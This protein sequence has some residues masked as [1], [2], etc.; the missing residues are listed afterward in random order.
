MAINFLQNWQSAILTQ[1]HIGRIA[2]G[3]APVR[4][5][6][7]WTGCLGSGPGPDGSRTGSSTL[8]S[9]PILLLH[10]ALFS[11]KYQAFI[12]NS[13]AYPHWPPSASPPLTL[14][15]SCP[16][17]RRY[18]VLPAVS[19]RL[20]CQHS[21]RC[22]AACCCGAGNAVEGVWQGTPGYTLLPYREWQGFGSGKG[23]PRPPTSVLLICH[24][25]PIQPARLQL[26][27]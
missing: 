15:H 12:M 5:P 4:G 27:F 17:A 26:P 22:C 14:R 3:P 21:L 7:F 18:P 1:P 2:L 19:L 6:T 20:R 24:L 8:C 13:C 10:F 16:E 11:C 23:G 9:S 25:Q